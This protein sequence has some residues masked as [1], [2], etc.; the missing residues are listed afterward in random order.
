MVCSVI[1]IIVLLILAIMGIAEQTMLQLPYS[2]NGCTAFHTF[3]CLALFDTVEL[4][5]TCPSSLS[6]L[7]QTSLIFNHPLLFFHCQHI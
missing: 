6:F 1:P 4:G 3:G 7:P 2:A 5:K